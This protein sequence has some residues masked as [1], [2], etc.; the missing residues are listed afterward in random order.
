[1]PLDGK[2]DHTCNTYKRDCET[3][4][5]ATIHCLS[6][7]GFALANFPGFMKASLP[8]FGTVRPYASPSGQQRLPNSK[9]ATCVSGVCQ[10]SL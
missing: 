7:F 10:S 1:M 3:Y 2:N 5:H 8:A 6:P 9:E 4:P